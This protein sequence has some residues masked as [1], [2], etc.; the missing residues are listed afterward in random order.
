[1]FKRIV[2]SVIGFPLL[3]MIIIIG[4]L[5]LKIVM[6]A[7]S[8]IG[9][10]EL[11]NAING[12]QSVENIISYIFIGIYYY[13]IDNITADSM[14]MLLSLYVIANLVCL[15]FFHGKIDPTHCAVNVFG[16]FYVGFLLSGIYLTRMHNYGQY[17]VWLIFICAWACD[18][19]AY[20]TGML[21]GK[22]KLAPV[23][24]PKKTVEGAIGGVI[25]AIVVAVIYGYF[26]Y[27]LTAISNDE[28]DLIFFCAVVA[29]F[30]SIFAQLGDLTASAIKRHTGIK[31]YGKI[32]P[33]HGGIIDRFDSVM[34][35][36]PIVYAVMRLL[37]RNIAG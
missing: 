21:I 26:A 30:G 28:L 35:T 25:G 9:M 11:Y 32:I 7:I 19:F 13:F 23:L 10:G 15:V 27:Q 8:A 33:G 2:T 34:F 24:S 12:K 1:M 14:I 16:F 22:H 29:G 36:A 6:I 37:L 5:P 4:G 31:D 18:T 17:F 20:F 3:A